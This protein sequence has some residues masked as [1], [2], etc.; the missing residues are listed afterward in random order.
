MK[1]KVL[2]FITIIVL[3]A[4]AGWNF[5]QDNHDLPLSDLTLENI[6]AL[7]QDEMRNGYAE[8]YCNNEWIGGIG[9][10]MSHSCTCTGNGNI[11]FCM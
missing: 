8:K 1:K 11:I 5:Q 4:V 10:S 9:G 6:N 7:A 3:A 2:S